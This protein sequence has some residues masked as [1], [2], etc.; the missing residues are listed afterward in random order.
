LSFASGGQTLCTATL[1]ELGTAAS[2]ASG[3]CT[4]SL[5]VGV[6]DV[7]A[8]VGGNYTGSVTSKVEVVKAQNRV[9]VG[10]GS[11]VAAK[12]AGAYLADKGSTAELSLA[13]AHVKSTSGATL[14]TF[15]SGGKRYQIR[16]TKVESFGAKTVGLLSTLDYRGKAELVDVTDHWRPKTVAT[17]LTLRITSKAELFGKDAAAITLLSGEKLLLSSEWTGART[18]DLP[19]KGTVVVI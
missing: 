17:G 11:L 10:G 7:T 19:L 14:V 16:S 6:H 18:A 2:D 3:S 8:T 13:L 15:Q 4:A 1:G 12:S 5:P 9:V